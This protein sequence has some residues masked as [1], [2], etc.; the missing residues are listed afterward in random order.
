V[1]QI[2]FDGRI[3]KARAPTEDEWEDLHRELMEWR[4][5][6]TE[7]RGTQPEAMPDELW[8]KL[9]NLI[10]RQLIQFS[11]TQEQKDGVRWFFV[12]NGLARGLGWDEAFE[13]ASD[14]LKGSRAKAGPDMM[15]TSY[16]NIQKRLP[17]E[18]RRPRTYRRRSSP[19]R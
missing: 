4:G 12:C 5:G 16:Q 9:I 18:K 10:D 14:V 19:L 7:W 6:L 1:F 15:K 11:W 13:H 3:E 17:P 8:A 2:T